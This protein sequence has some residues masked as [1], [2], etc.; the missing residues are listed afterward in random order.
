MKFSIRVLSMAAIVLLYGCFSLL[1][2]RTPGEK[3]SFD[4]SSSTYNYPIKNNYP[5][6]ISFCIVDLK[7]DGQFI[8]ICE[9]G[10][11]LTSQF[12][13]YD[14]LYGQGALWATVWDFFGSFQRPVWLVGKRFFHNDKRV[15]AKGHL[16]AIGGKTSDSIYFL[17]Q[18]DVFKKLVKKAKKEPGIVNKACI[19][20][21]D[22][23]SEFKKTY[24]SCIV[25]GQA[26]N[27]I[28]ANKYRTNNL[29]DN[30]PDISMFK[31][32]FKAYPKQYTLELASQ[33]V[34]DLGC[35]M[36]VIKPVDA[37]LG[38]GIIMVTRDELNATLKLIFKDFKRFNKYQLDDY[39]YGYWTRDHN[40]NFIVEEFATS[41]TIYV[42]DKPYDPTMR[43]VF[44]ISNNGGCISTTF[45]ASY[46]KLPDKNLDQEGTFTDKHKSHVTYKSLVGSA[47][48]EKKDFDHVKELLSLVLP[49]VYLKMLAN[50]FDKQIRS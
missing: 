7:Y 24:P 41:K 18:D 1:D 3:R 5:D 39:S 30:D 11:G 13:G 38:R 47:E 34:K 26:T 29:F 2:G 9:F 32:L 49:K 48:V 31:P 36:F 20:I 23:G 8:K 50:C 6:E 12:K 15:L 37:S 40:K 19:L 25:V 14:R 17:K 10:E 28:V 21:G 45:L 27:G 33:I 35:S 44:V 42:N 43:V 22:C 16:S 46:W 4:W